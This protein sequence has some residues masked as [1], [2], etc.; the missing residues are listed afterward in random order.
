MS[1]LVIE[2]EAVAARTLI[3]WLAD[4][5]PEFAIEAPL[6]SVAA[7]LERLQSPP[8]PELILM[9]VHLADGLCFDLFDVLPL[10]T[11]VI[12]TTAYDQYALRAFE[13][14][15]VDYLLKPL[16]PDRLALALSKWRRL[17]GSPAAL[18]GAA[19]A[20][21]YFQETQ[22]YRQRL[23]VHIG[24]VMQSLELSE[25]AY[26]VKDLLVRAVTLE[27]KAYTLPQ[28]LEE[29]EQTLSPQRFFRL[30][31]QVLAQ[32]VAIGRVHKGGKGR[33]DVELKPP[34]NEA[35]TISQERAGAFKAWLEG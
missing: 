21:R 20:H 2:D 34:L 35:V 14:Y 1:I 19:V 7:A 8:A 4:L 24:S 3:K 15:G 31:R 25:I 30:N 23:L 26:F 17:R 16:R 18:P 12:F 29:L 10:T 13:V 22:A 11:P 5:A 28:T 6:A 32:I 27:G 9:D 33:L